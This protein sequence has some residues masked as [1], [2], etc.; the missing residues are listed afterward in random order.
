VGRGEVPKILSRRFGSI[1]PQDIPAMPR[2]N[3]PE[4]GH[5]FLG[6]QLIAELGRGAFGRVYLAR[7]GELSDRPVVLKISADV[8]H[9]SRTLAQLQHTNIVPIYSIHHAPTFHAVCMPFLGATTLADVLRDVQ[10]AGH[11]PASGKALVDTVNAC[12]SKTQ[13]GNKSGS[14]SSASSPS[15]LPVS[16]GVG[17]G[18][19]K[20]HHANG[21]HATVSSPQV[22][23]FQGADI[24]ATL[25]TLAGLSYVEAVLWIG[26][27][28]ADG[29]DHAHDHGIFHRDLKPANILLANDG[30]PMLLDFNLS[31]DLKLRSRGM[32]AS[33]I[34]G[35]LPYMS[36]EHLT[37][38]LRGTSGVDARSDLYSLGVI[39]YELLTGRHP[40]PLRQGHL[41][42]VIGQ[43]LEDRR[44]PPPALRQLNPAVS[45]AV[46][47][48]VLHCLDGNP[49]RRYQTASAL[50]EDLDR[51]LKN[52][53]LRH[54]REPSLRERGRKW[55]RRHP[56]LTS[57]TT[58]AVVATTVILVMAA[59]LAFR[60]ERLSRLEAAEAHNKLRQDLRAAQVGFLETPTTGPNQ[61]D[62]SVA[63]CRKALD[64][65]DV[66][67]NPAWQ[68]SSAFQRLSTESQEQLRGEVG[69]LLF[70]LAALSTGWDA[71]QG[72]SATLGAALELNL[73]AA[74]CYPSDHMPVALLYQRAVLTK[75]HGQPDEATQLLK[76]AEGVS[77]QTPRDLCMLACV[78]SGQARFRQALPLWQKATLAD[79]RNVWAW[80]GL[81]NCYD[82]LSRP[83]QAAACYSACIALHRDF[84]GW[85]ANRGLANLKQ[86]EFA[87]ACL[88][89]DQ[90]IRLQPSNADA[91]VNRGLAKLGAHQCQEAVQ[92]LTKAIQLGASGARIYFIRA[93]AREKIGDAVG[94]KNDR[95]TGTNTK[96]ADEA[97]W[98]AQGVSRVSDNPK[99][100][101]SDFDQALVHNPRSLAALESKAH[102]LAEKLGR[103]ED[104]IQVL[105]KAVAFYPEQAP[106]LAAR[107]VLLAR[108]GQREMAIR[109]AQ[110]AMRLDTSPAICYQVAGIYALTSKSQP[111]DR[112]KAFSLLAS[113]LRLGYGVDLILTDSDLDPIRA[114]GEFQAM[115][116]A[117]KTLSKGSE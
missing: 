103:T 27:R 35:T 83:D 62:T 32:P 111:D 34:G 86:K 66:V 59:S 76:K 74:A 117:V 104:A 31:E 8:I 67:G 48:I 106:A 43:M 38:F 30:Q 81:G 115:L 1:A 113:A 4:V 3:M 69:V 51:H 26:A 114:T 73:Q 23:D 12:K 98:I 19:E 16:S 9:E 11:L 6:F 22:L 99:G 33:A 57:A 17:D 44:Q 85:Y 105:N 112:L 55:I 64:R 80:Y 49:A 102:V 36:P 96:Q 88:D 107:G 50:K 94:A 108:L 42:V 60:A 75:Q 28:L 24:A 97:A 100:A 101:L 78:Y 61:W 47:A 87:A 5:K 95:E 52:L 39:L 72:S 54:F 37:A 63:L 77:P 71:A 7:Q 79:P 20:S 68:E 65:F 41:E 29:L 82:H 40:Y 15:L 93:Q 90:V 46:E 2:D 110:E 58:I 70:L 89:F 56:R 109:D 18:F 91:H 116:S 53:P 84:P 13:V 45:P 25:K 10:K 21:K 92:D 14:L